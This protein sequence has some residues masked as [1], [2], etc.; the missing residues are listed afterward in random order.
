MSD[1]TLTAREMDNRNLQDTQIR[2]RASVLL[3]TRRLS[4]IINK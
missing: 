4:V 3:S 2:A 1:E